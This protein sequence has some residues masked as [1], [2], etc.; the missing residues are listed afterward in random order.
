MD[1]RGASG[2][3][4]RAVPLRPDPIEQ[5]RLAA[6]YIDRILRG[7]ELTRPWGRQSRF[8]SDAGSVGCRDLRQSGIR[9]EMV[10]PG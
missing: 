8:V 5:F 6:D 9:L 2:K 1:R 4:R 3:S 7:D 10:W